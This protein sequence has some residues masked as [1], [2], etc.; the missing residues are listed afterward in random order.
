MFISYDANTE[1]EVVIDTVIAA[2]DGHD[3]K[4]CQIPLFIL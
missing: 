4:D 3:N 2:I 1:N